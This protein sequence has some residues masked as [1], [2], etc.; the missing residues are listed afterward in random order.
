V[1]PKITP[2]DVQIK[3]IDQDGRM[4]KILIIQPKPTE[5]TTKKVK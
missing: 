3:K 1:A 2:A 4:T 5:F